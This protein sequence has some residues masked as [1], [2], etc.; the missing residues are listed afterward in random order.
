MVIVDGLALNVNIPA[1]TPPRAEGNRARGGQPSEDPNAKR[2]EKLDAIRDQFLAALDYAKVVTAAEAGKA[3]MPAPDPRFAALAP[4]ARG[5]KPVIFIAERRM[6]I[7]DALKLAEELKLK[8]IISGASEAW[9]V[10]DELKAA[11]VSVLIAGSLRV[12]LDPADPYDSAYMNAAKLHAAGIPFA[13]RSIGQ[14]PDQATSS[15]NLPFEAAN[16]AAY[17]LPEAEA[18]KAVTLRAAEILGVASQLGSL[19]VGKRAN[20]VITQ[21]PLLQVTSDVKALFIHGKPVTTETRHTRLNAKYRGRLAE[22]RAG[23]APLGLVRNPVVEPTPTP[24]KVNTGGEG[25]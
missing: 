14:G 13:I 22:V 1:Y 19:E 18:I 10:V 12:P 25:R 20:L 5:E 11:K 7:L 15:R 16:A 8:A 2:K 24:T 23:R 3:A 4:F 17:G 6:E 9:K 21:G